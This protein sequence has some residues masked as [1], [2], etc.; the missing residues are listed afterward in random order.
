MQ[1]TRKI[2][3]STGTL[4]YMTDSEMTLL[5]RAGR[6]TLL[7]H[8]CETESNENDIKKFRKLTNII[9]RKK[10]EASLDKYQQM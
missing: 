1:V 9:Y 7:Y 5:C 10:T 3:Y 6:Q 2:S 4:K 8:T